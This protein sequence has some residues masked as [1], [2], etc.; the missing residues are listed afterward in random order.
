MW[1]CHNLISKSKYCWRLCRSTGR[2]ELE[3]QLS[4]IISQSRRMLSCC[5]VRAQ[6]QCLLSRKGVIS[7]EAR[8]AVAVAGRL[9]REL[10]QERTAQWMAS[11]RGPGWARRGRCHM[12]AWTE[13]DLDGFGIFCNTIDTIHIFTATRPPVSLPCWIFS[14]HQGSQLWIYCFGLLLTLTSSNKC[15]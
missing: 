10:R 4:V 2:P 6:A 13:L 12:M 3:G 14:V 7:P 8:G 9:E 1:K 11:I 15:W 5:I